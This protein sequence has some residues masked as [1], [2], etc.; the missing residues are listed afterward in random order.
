MSQNIF[1]GI[2]R[3]FFPCSRSCRTL[4][5]ISVLHRRLPLSLPLG[6]AASSARSAERR[7]D[8]RSAEKI[9]S[10]IAESQRLFVLCLCICPS[11]TR[12]YVYLLCHVLCLHTYVYVLFCICL[13][14]MSVC[15]VLCLCLCPFLYLPIVY[16]RLSTSMSTTMSFRTVLPSWTL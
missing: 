9:A 5:R 7:P 8:V 6:R 11:S 13:L 10:L 2:S 12:N 3:D 16:V 4:Q 15:H 14:S 1:I